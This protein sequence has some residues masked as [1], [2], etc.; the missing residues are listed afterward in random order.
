MKKF[1]KISKF[2]VNSEQPKVGIV[3][4][5]NT[6][7]KYSMYKLIED[8]LHIRIEGPIDPIL[9]GSIVIDGKEE[10][11]NAIIEFIK[12]DE[13]KEQ[14]KLLENAKFDG[15]DN[16]INFLTYK[17]NEAQIPSERAKHIKRV[18]D[19]VTKVGDDVSKAKLETERQA[20]R[21]KNGEKAYYRSVAAE[22]LI[23]E[24][25]MNK[26][27]LKEISKTFLFRSKQL[28]YRK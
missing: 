9:Q 4:D 2:K 23:G 14:V 25:E 5:N 24:D 20:N 22:D 21:I 28:G 16:T 7:L 17:I 27:V 3:N 26:K 6:D 8:F 10:F 11:I 15:V 12:Q 19:L 13:V 18:K 1:S